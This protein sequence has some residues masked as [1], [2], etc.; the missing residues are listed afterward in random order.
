MV[1][2]AD[3]NS[4]RGCYHLARVVE[5]CPG[6]DGLVRRVMICYKNFKAGD[7]LYEYTGGKDVTVSRSVQRLA[8][9]VPADLYSP[10]V[11][12]FFGNDGLVHGIRQCSGSLHHMSINHPLFMCSFLIGRNF[13]LTFDLCAPYFYFYYCTQLT[14]YL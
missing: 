4:L 7:T 8:L 6:G 13:P 5:V 14:K 9:L 1:A 12:Q 11:E 10:A 3:S 2:V